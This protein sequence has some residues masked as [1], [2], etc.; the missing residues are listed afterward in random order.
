M[1]ILLKKAAAKKK[2]KNIFLLPTPVRKGEG[3][4]R[5][6]AE[7]GVLP[8]ISSPLQNAIVTKISSDASVV[9]WL[10]LSC[11]SN[12]NCQ[13]D[14]GTFLN[15]NNF[16]SGSADISRGN[17]AFINVASGKEGKWTSADCTSDFKAV[18]CQKS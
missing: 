10:G 6:L 4:Q 11:S 2:R 5:C 1:L 12:T 13:W 14:D 7:G 15:F 16:D 17:C 18:I 9:T 8:K 3:Q